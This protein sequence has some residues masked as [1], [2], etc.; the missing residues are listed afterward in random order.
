MISLYLHGYNST[1]QNE[2]TDWLSGFGKIINPLMSYR[3]FV[4]NY[5]FLE[6]LIEK[7]HPD[8]IVGS[9]LGGYFAFHLGNYYRIPTILLN[10][11]LLMT[12]IVK[13]D[14][15]ILVTDTL[16]TI[17]IGKNDT[18]IPPKTTYAVLQQL[19]AR[20]QIKEYD[21]GHETSFEVFLDICKKSTLFNFI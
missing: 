1:H 17:S 4:E 10:P 7:N 21:M 3:N 2:R 16:H 6:Q 11:A 20:Y 14:N 9:S 5:K 15:R 18:V 19:D 13:P 12:N 8:V